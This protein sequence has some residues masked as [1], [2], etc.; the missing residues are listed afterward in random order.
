MKKRKT[1]LTVLFSMA[2]ACMIA[3]CAAA[4]TAQDQEPYDE[5]GFRSGGGTTNIFTPLEVDGDMT[6]DGKLDEARWTGKEWFSF[7]D[8]GVTVQVTTSISDKGVYI[9][10]KNNDSQIFYNS[11][12]DIW[13]NSSFEIYIDRFDSMQKTENTLQVRIDSG[14]IETYFGYPDAGDGYAWKAQYRPV[15]GEINVDGEVNSGEAKGMSCELFIRWDALGYTISDAGFEAPDSVKLFPAYSKASGADTE[16]REAWCINSEGYNDT[17]GYWL[18]G[19]DGFEQGDK[20][21][22]YIGDYLLKRVKTPGWDTSAEKGGK[23][24]VKST[25]GNNQWIYFTDQNAEHIGEA[26]SYAFTAL[27]SFKNPINDDWPRMGVTLGAD[28]ENIMAFLLRMWENKED[29]VVGEF[30]RRTYSGSVW[31]M[32]SPSISIEGGF[33]AMDGVRITGVKYGAALYVFVGD[34]ASEKFGGEFVSLKVFNDMKGNAVPGFFT[35]GCE[36]EFSDYEITGNSETIKGILKGNVAFMNV[37]QDP[38]GTLSG[39]ENVYP[40]AEDSY[41]SLKISANDGYYLSSL[42]VNG[43]EKMSEVEEG[44]L[45][46]CTNADNINV[47]PQFTK[48]TETLYQVSGTIKMSSEIQINLIE[49]VVQSQ[50]EAG[51]LIIVRPYIFRSG[52]SYKVQLQLPDG[53]Y[54][55]VL[56]YDEKTV[57]SENFTVNGGNLQLPEIGFEETYGTGKGGSQSVGNWNTAL[58]PISVCVDT[59]ATLRNNYIFS[60]ENGNSSSFF[61]EMTIKSDGSLISGNDWPLAGVVLQNTAAGASNYR[62]VIQVRSGSLSMGAW[63]DRAM[64]ITWLEGDSD[65]RVNAEEPA[66]TGS[67]PADRDGVKLTVVRDGT[68]CYIFVN[69]RFICNYNVGFTENMLTDIGLSSAGSIAEFSGMKYSEERSLIDEWIALAAQPETEIILSANE[70]KFPGNLSGAE[71]YATGTFKH[72]VGSGWNMAGFNVTVG[73]DVYRIY[74]QFDANNNDTN[75]MII[76]QND[77][78][79]ARNYWKADSVMPYLGSTEYTFSIALKNG[80]LYA[81]LMQFDTDGNAVTV[82]WTIEAATEA[83]WG[84]HKG[85]EFDVH[86]AA[87]FGSTEK[88][89]GLQCQDGTATAKA[90]KLSFDENEINAFVDG[91]KQ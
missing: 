51:K 45:S 2:A 59:G 85:S 89:I 1:V 15:Y 78:W 32:L 56:K 58:A 76:H 66:Y 33:N 19:R 43:E 22:A 88:K 55:Y 28:D 17:A 7:T 49:I 16:S 23:G 10:L 47:V 65:R 61:Y 26:D 29:S 35:M 77:P 71:F 70:T 62:M 6:I 24:Y 54:S 34:A 50:Y 64:L 91:F 3:G 8:S 38:N 4:A 69:D 73:T 68:N 36:V 80:V 79:G 83:G 72:E 48:M 21:D 63:A 9:A 46:V 90:F 42:K 5:T 37:E 44:S 57:S 12:R 87:L 31:E 52:N 11:G 13:L 82:R 27:L 53:T 14:K 25:R 75:L 40:K 67:R 74:P 81:E 60:T 18:F 84:D 39:F 30:F 41:A 20:D 86:Y